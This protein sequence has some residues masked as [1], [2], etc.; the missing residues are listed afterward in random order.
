MQEAGC[1]SLLCCVVFT[2][3]LTWGGFGGREGQGW[4]LSGSWVRGHRVNQGTGQAHLIPRGQAVCGLRPPDHGGSG[5]DTVGGLS[6]GGCGRLGLRKSLVTGSTV[7]GRPHACAGPES[8]GPSEKS[9]QVPSPLHAPGCGTQPLC[10]LLPEAHRRHVFCGF[11][12]NLGG[13]QGSLRLCRVSLPLSLLLILL[14][15]PPPLYSL[16]DPVPLPPEQQNSLSFPSTENFRDHHLFLE[17]ARRVSHLLL[18]A[19]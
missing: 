11:G 19:D 13:S 8:S 3:G 7:E 16:P 5:G 2:H 17:Q 10:S 6:C 18:T 12:E 14:P 4:S 15:C 9:V 1:F